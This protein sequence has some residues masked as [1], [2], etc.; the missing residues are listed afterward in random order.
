M[1]FPSEPFTIKVMEPLRRPIHPELEIVRP[2]TPRRVY[3]IMQIA[4]VAESIIDLYRRRAF[5]RGLAL[6]YEAPMLRHFT[7]QFIE[8]RESQRR[9]SLTA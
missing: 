2:A 8:L 7:A 5:I 6:T 9:H 3:T 1:K 4:H